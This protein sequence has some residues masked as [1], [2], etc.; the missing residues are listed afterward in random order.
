MEGVATMS[1]LA[2]GASAREGSTAPSA[3]QTRTPVPSTLVR[4]E[5]LARMD[6]TASSVSAA[7]AM[8]EPAV[9]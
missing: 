1:L 9:S 2:S 6:S 7:P 8:R 4:M 5:G 3:S